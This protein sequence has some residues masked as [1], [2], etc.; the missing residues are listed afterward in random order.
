MGKIA[1][2]IS[3]HNCA[4]FCKIFVFFQILSCT[5]VLRKNKKT[6]QNPVFLCTTAI[7]CVRL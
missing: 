6:E 7:V 3:Q 1:L 2:L 5:F 4:T